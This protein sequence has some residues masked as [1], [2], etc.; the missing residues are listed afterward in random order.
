MKK[1]T[2]I[3]AAIL[4]VLVGVRVVL[5]MGGGDDKALVKEAL[6]ESIKAS[7][8]GRPGGV[9]DKI[10][11]HMTVN[12]QE[13][14]TTRQIADWIKNLKPDVVVTKPEPV[15]LGDEA[16]ITSPVSIKG[17]GMGGFSFDKTIDNV[18][19]IFARENATEWLIIPT[20]KWRLKDVKLPDDIASQLNPF[21]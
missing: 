21:G 13:V 18:T 5:S 19:L 17:S 16:Q 20:K 8:E 12:G 3:I 15:I 10:S 14:A 6:Q 7:K 9:M 11:D 4:V 1:P 2:L